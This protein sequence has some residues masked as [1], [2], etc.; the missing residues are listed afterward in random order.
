M[1]SKKEFLKGE[2]VK[3]KHTSVSG[4]EVLGRK[5]GEGRAFTRLYHVDM[6]L[7]RPTIMY[8]YLGFFVWTDDT[9]FGL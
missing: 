9:I 7:S 4:Y 1:Q 5:A 8:Q 2:G 3:K 6:G